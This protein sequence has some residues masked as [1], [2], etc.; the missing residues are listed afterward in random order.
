MKKPFTKIATALVVAAMVIVAAPAS[1]QQ[2]QPEIIVNLDRERIFEGESVGYKVMLNNVDRPTAPDMSAF[3]DFEVTSTGSQSMNMTSMRFINGRSTMVQRRGREYSYRLTPRKSGLLTVPAPTAKVNGRVL[4]GDEL[5]LRVVPPED[6]DVVRM[7]ITS[8]PESVY[9][10]Q[11]V[12][13]TLSIYI[14]PLPGELSDKNPLRVLNRAPNL[15]IPWMKDEQLPDGLEP[16][17]TWK[18]WIRS[19]SSEVRSG[20]VVNNLEEVRNP[21]MSFFEERSEL[22]FEPRPTRVLKNDDA[23]KPQEYWAYRFRRTFIPKIPGKYTFGPAALK[24]LFADGVSAEGRLKGQDIYT[25]ARPLTITIKDVPEQGRPD[26]YVGLVG[27]FSVDA[28]LSPK[29]AKVGDPMTLTLKVTGQGTLE[30]AR[31]PDLAAVPEIAKRFKVYD[32]TE[33]TDSGSISFTYSLRPLEMGDEPFPSI[34][35]S[36]FDVE[37]DRYET[38]KTDP[39]EISIGKAEKLSNRQIVAARHSSGGGQSQIEARRE[40]IF[41]NITDLDAVHNDSVRPL[42]WFVGLGCMA[43]VYVVLFFGT[44]RVKRLRGDTALL[45]R[46]GAAAAARGRLREGLGLLGRGEIRPGTEAV[47]D[48]VTGLVADTADTAQAGLTPKDVAARLERFGVSNDIVKRA[49]ALLE[50]CDAA[51]YAAAGLDAAQIANESKSVLDGL[52]KELKSKGLFK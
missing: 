30:N 13:V 25:I 51:R 19:Y 17:T 5:V 45:R 44:R 24:G 38:I 27:K 16:K 41:A 37:A 28:A 7:E 50:T 36:Y 4:K 2:P 40:G 15:T 9:P 52:V 14:K 8:E 46:R 10:M 12:T 11:P 26:S 34:P 32:A 39:I 20:F 6:Q 42:Y 3:K 29:K 22:L 47:K 1:A 21:I 35:I 18:N 23:G 43:A 49:S 31:A 33:K 48:A